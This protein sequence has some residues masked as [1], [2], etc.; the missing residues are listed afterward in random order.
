MKTYIGTK[1]VRA[2]AM[3]RFAYNAL[4]GWMVPADE[5]GADDGYLVE[6]LDGGKPNVP[7][8]AGY[9]SWSPKEQFDKAYVSVANLSFGMALEALKCG[10]RVARA[11]WNG[12]GQWVTMAGPKEGTKVHSDAFWSANNAEFA[13]VQPDSEV[14]VTPYFTIKS[15]Q[16]EIAVWVPSTSD[17]LANDWRVLT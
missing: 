5:N 12:N 4:R 14:T 2:V 15:A 8:Y 7:G 9:V 16:D 11:G 13:R 17:C 1:V 3:T 10:F 6:Y